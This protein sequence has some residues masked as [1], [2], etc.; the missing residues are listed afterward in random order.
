MPISYSRTAPH[1]GRPMSDMNVTPFI[2]VLL[3]L[4][5]ML[6]MVVPLAT[7]SLEIPLPNGK[8]KF[9]VRAANTVTIDAQ[10]RLYWNGQALTRQDLLNQLASS[11]RDPRDPVL[12][13]E[14]NGL[15]SYEA[16]ARTI[17]LIK[18]SGV[19]NFAFIGN[20]RHKDFRTD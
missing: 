20:D 10:D 5:I 6:I 12:R 16:S 3:V 11:A 1:H 17:A 4:I 9:E 18:D 7:H 8:G 2:D 14:P 19:K 13:F 15:A